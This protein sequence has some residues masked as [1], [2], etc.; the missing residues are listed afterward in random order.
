[1][2]IEHIAENAQRFPFFR[3]PVAKG[4]YVA[5]ARSLACV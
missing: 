4:E 2:I 5:P 1:M 3:A